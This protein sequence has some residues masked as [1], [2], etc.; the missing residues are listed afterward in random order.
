M[1]IHLIY[2]SL[3]S[4]MLYLQI[5]VLR[6]GNY[7]VSYYSAKGFLP[8][9]YLLFL[10]YPLVNLKYINNILFSNKPNYSKETQDFI[11]TFIGAFLSNK[12]SM[13][14]YKA[15]HFLGIVFWLYGLQFLALVR[16]RKELRKNHNQGKYAL[17]YP[18]RVIIGYQSVFSIIFGICYLL[19]LKSI[20]QISQFAIILLYTLWYG[21]DLLQ[22]GAGFYTQAN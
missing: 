8:A 13:I 7:L 18:E 6:Q 19:K 21:K 16:E 2:G 1:L 12:F 20:T 3:V 4:T 10:A 15:L 22:I 5:K 14:D 11:I 9:K 17:S